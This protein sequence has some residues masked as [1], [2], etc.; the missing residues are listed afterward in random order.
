MSTPSKP[1]GLTGVEWRKLAH[2][3]RRTAAKMI[4]CGQSVAAA[5]YMGYA[6]ECALKAACCKSLK[7][8]RYPPVK[9]QKH[10]GGVNEIEIHQGFRTH[11]IDS[12]IIFSGLYKF[13]RLG[14]SAYGNFS[15]EYTGDW[16]SLIRYDSDY[17]AKFTP[18][19]VKELYNHLY[20]D[21]SS[22]L[23]TIM[24]AHKW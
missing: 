14:C 22:I 2:A 6:L 21:D 16:T 15:T 17:Q 19:R 24:R 7:I 13:L 12:L 8:D 18:Q 23:K 10:A 3:K 4:E 1:K 20:K 9:T 11:E 5:E